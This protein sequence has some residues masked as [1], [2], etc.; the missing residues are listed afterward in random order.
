MMLDLLH[1][2]E[3]PEHLDRPPPALW[4]CVTATEEVYYRLSQ[5]FFSR[6]KGVRLPGPQQREDSDLN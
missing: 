2:E 5:I 6:S 4:A 3:K 1:S